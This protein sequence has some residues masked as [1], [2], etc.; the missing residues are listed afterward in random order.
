MTI[1]IRTTATSMTTI[2]TAPPTP[3]YTRMLLVCMFGD[4]NEAVG[5]GITDVNVRNGWKHP[6]TMLHT[7]SI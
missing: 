7:D 3:P 5:I 4:V 1:A 2:P 6:F